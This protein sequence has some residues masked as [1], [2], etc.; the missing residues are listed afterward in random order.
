MFFFPVFLLMIFGYAINFDVKHI[1]IAV[2][3][4]E[5]S[6]MSRDFIKS[7]Q[8]SEYFDLVRYVNNYNEIDTYLDEK[9]AQCVV[10]IPND[11]TKKI[12]KVGTSPTCNV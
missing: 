3:D 6:T 1:K 10:V 8:N 2:L 12:T 4:K 11:L 7:L 5:K 9:V